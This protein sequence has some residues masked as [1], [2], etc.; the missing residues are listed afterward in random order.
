VQGETE[1]GTAKLFVMAEP[2][3]TATVRVRVIVAKE[4]VGFRV[5]RENVAQCADITEIELISITDATKENWM[6]G[7]KPWGKS[8][9]SAFT[10]LMASKGGVKDFVVSL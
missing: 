2:S 1:V 4:F 7:V 9:G 8:I 6:P 3:L 5:R 10:D